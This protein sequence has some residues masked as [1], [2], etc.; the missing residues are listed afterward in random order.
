MGKCPVDNVVQYKIDY[1]TNWLNFGVDGSQNVDNFYDQNP[2]T[3][4]RESCN[5][6]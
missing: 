6:T 5:N 4:W 2:F 3:L 1:I